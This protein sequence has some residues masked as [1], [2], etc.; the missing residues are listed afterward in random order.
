MHFSMWPLSW[1]AAC[2]AE[3][4]PLV[5]ELG[6]VE[7]AACRKVVARAEILAGRLSA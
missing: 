6:L 5:G 3:N 4:V 2:G 7:C 1:A